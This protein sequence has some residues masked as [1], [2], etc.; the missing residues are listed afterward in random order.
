MF[1]HVARAAYDWVDL[2]GGIGGWD[3][4]RCGGVRGVGNK[5]R[6]IGRGRRSLH[7][8]RAV[9]DGID[10]EDL[11]IPAVVTENA[12]GTNDKERRTEQRRYAIGVGDLVIIHRYVLLGLR[13]RPR[14]R[15][16]LESGCSLRNQGSN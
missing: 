9:S 15:L 12:E 3:R 7:G 5:D 4:S 2:D 13:L 6:H 11:A 14:G 10:P 1:L 16:S 8:S